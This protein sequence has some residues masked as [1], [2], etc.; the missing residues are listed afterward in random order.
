MFIITLIMMNLLIAI[1]SDTYGEMK[2]TLDVVVH[3]RWL[4]SLH[5]QE[6]LLR[7]AAEVLDLFTGFSIDE[8][9]GYRSTSGYLVYCRY[10]Q[11]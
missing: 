9:A 10:D 6:R 2:Q 3:Q 7:V 4:D 5:S 1:V 11:G 8:R